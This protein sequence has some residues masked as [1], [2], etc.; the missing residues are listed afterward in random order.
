[1]QHFLSVKDAIDVQALVK[2]ALLFKKTP[3]ADKHLG[4]N[5]QWDFC[6]SIRVSEH[7]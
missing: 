1:M 3:Y 4:K 7:V 6:S 2:E 5:A